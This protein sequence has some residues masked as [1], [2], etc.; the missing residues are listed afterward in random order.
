MKCQAPRRNT[1]LSIELFRLFD[2]RTQRRVPNVEFHGG[3]GRGGE[4]LRCYSEM[5]NHNV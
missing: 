3:G 2:A 5:T 4:A 1:F